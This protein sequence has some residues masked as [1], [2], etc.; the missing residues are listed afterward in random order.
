MANLR[1]SLI[2]VAGIILVLAG[3]YG[4]L[5]LASPSQA[6][7]SAES[8]TINGAGATLAY[9]LLSLTAS[10]YTQIHPNV[11]VNYQ[12]MGSVAGIKQFTLKTVDFGATYP[13]MNSQQRRQAPNALH[14]PEAISALAIAYH[15]G[16]NSPQGVHLTGPVI[17]Q[18]FLGNIQYWDDAAIQSLNPGLILPH[19]A[20]TS[21][22]QEDGDGT[23]F[24]FTSYLSE[25]SSEWQSKV[26][27]GTL[28]TWLSGVGVPT[29]G[30]VGAS[31][32]TT[33]YSIGYMELSY[34]L[35]SNLRYAA[36]QNPAGNW[37]LPSASSAKAADE[38]LKTAL[39]S[40]DGDWSDIN[41]LNEPGLDAYPLVTFT[42]IIVYR[43][44]NVVPYMDLEK[45]KALVGF[46]WYI[47]HDGQSLGAELQYVPL[48][49]DVVAINE[50]SIRS[51]TFAGHALLTS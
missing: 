30:G 3:A 33:D 24:M 20:I 32:S 29:S 34:A 9:P 47:T 39:P 14:I 43:E 44:L 31:V 12:P 17:A 38:Q 21:V 11:L 25:V 6:S 26:G 42:Y 40:G 7:V 41:L 15:I 35:Q 16:G 37:I 50:Q 5:V 46:L 28:V 48:T 36:I 4:G 19:G 45:A 51:I 27:A 10:S 22:H 18:I 13:P 23:T 49:P 8:T 1:L 2:G